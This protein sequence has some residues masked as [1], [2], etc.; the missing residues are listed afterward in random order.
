MAKQIIDLG[1][2]PKG[3]D[4]DTS[5]VAFEKAQQNFDELYLRE[6]GLLEKD[7]SG[8]GTVALTEAE[9]LNGIILLT[10]VLTGNRIVTVPASL[11]QPYIVRNS[12][13]GAFTLTF[14]TSSGS[15]LAISQGKTA[16][17]Y[18]DGTNIVD[19]F[20][21]TVAGLS[22]PG[23]LIGIRVFVASATYIETPGT[24]SVIAELQA[25]GG[26]GGG[27]V[28][29]AAGAF[30]SGSGGGAGGYMQVRMT[31]GFSGAAIVIGAAGVGVVGG[32][33][34]AGGTTSFG[35]YSVSGGSGGGVSGSSA[36]GA[37]VGFGGSGGGVSTFT[38]T[39]KSVPGTHGLP[40]AIVSAGV[41]MIG[42]GA[43]SPMSQGGLGGLSA[44]GGA[45]VGWGGGGGGVVN[46]STSAVKGGNGSGGKV[47][48]WEFA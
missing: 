43:P 6:Q 37:S 12:T 23:R 9:A 19:P 40:S 22:F 21:S 27:A 30:S 39:I 24:T 1:T 26:A 13:S 14:Q 34:G 35:G 3:T 45:A 16:V 42:S 5:R 28:A 48:V 17:G 15:G 38:G 29:N 4:G 18:S 33:G 11:T 7:V 8:T 46:G 2:P 31:S 32:N 47:I 41:W 10:G 36:A 44:D 25:P 20:T